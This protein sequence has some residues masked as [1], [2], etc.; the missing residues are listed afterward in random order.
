MDLLVSRTDILIFYA[1]AF[2][3]RGEDGSTIN[4]CTVHY[5]FW[6]ENGTA[7]VGQSDRKSTRLNSSHP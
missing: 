6:G 4:G 5:M 3:S 2:D 1:N 7:L